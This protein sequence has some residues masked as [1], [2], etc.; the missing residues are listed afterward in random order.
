MEAFPIGQ[1]ALRLYINNALVG[2]NIHQVE[3]RQTG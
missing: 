2:N 1:G 3:A